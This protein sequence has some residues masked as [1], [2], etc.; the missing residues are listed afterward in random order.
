MADSHRDGMTAQAKVLLMALDEEY[1]EK[2]I[3]WPEYCRRG[4]EIM[5]NDK[6]NWPAPHKKANG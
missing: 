4:D 3:N 5:K 6:A 2:L 1:K